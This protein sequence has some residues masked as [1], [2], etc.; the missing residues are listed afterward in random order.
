MQEEL[1]KVQIDDIFEGPMDLLVHLIKKHEVDIYD[2]PIA[3]ITEQYLDYLQWMKAINIDVAGDFILMASTLTKIKSKMLLPIH[4]EET[5]DEDP[6][7]EIVKPLEEYLQMKSAANELMARNLLGEDTF[8]RHLNQEDRSIDQDGDII[9]VGLFE[10][11]DAFQSIL[12]KIS[13]HRS[14]DII[15]ADTISVRDRIVQIVDILETRKSVSFHELFSM[16]TDK[17]EV[18]V[19]FLAILEMVRLSLINIV[20]NTQTGIIK[21]FYL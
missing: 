1:Y 2:I 12:E 14:V 4:E 13:G 3:L 15:T 16:N 5:D 7:L 9:K 20:Q 21:L 8:V 10:L 6:R 18:V 17:S 11:I 19:T